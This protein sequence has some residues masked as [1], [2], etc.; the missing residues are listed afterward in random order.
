[1]FV[2][3]HIKLNLSRYRY[4]HMF[5]YTYKAWIDTKN[6]EVS[7]AVSV[8]LGNLEFRTTDQKQKFKALNKQFSIRIKLSRKWTDKK[9]G[10]NS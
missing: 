4:L 7:I 8:K 1:M 9:L 2:Y 6:L 3:I 10:S 5:V